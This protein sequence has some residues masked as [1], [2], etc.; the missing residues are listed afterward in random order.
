MVGIFFSL[1]GWNILNPTPELCFGL[2]LCLG[3]KC[4]QTGFCSSCDTYSWIVHKCVT[5]FGPVW[6]WWHVLLKILQKTCHQ[7]WSFTIHLPKV[8]AILGHPDL[9]DDH[10][11]LLHH[12]HP[13]LYPLH[14]HRV[15]P[16]HLLLDVLIAIVTSHRQGTPS[17]S[18]PELR[19]PR[20]CVKC[21]QRCNHL[22]DRYFC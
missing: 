14:T 6:S 15:H 2:F 3:K 13:G 20:W 9:H 19:L 5:K 10:H 17:C 8:P 1:Y 7:Y 21:Y 18:S 12:H 22:T 11:H 16:Q 4:K